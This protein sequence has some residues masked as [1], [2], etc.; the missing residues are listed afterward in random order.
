MGDPGSHQCRDDSNSD[1]SVWASGT[2]NCRAQDRGSSSLP[3]V[4][5]DRDRYMVKGAP[6]ASGDTGRA[7]STGPGVAE[8]A[9][10]EH[11]GG[12]GILS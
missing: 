12:T 4:S 5:G 11:K 6:P 10:V 3:N 8:E 2:P 7:Q 9:S 1:M